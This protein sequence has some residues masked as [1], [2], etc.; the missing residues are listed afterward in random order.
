MNCNCIFPKY[1]IFHDDV[2]NEILRPGMQLRRFH[3]LHS[4][5]QPVGVEVVEPWAQ[6]ALFRFLPSSWVYMLI[7]ADGSGF[8]WLVR[9][10]V[11]Y[12]VH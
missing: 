2:F 1:C 10:M 8:V 3:L 11:L 7:R 4:G 12:W 6:L 5:T 9:G